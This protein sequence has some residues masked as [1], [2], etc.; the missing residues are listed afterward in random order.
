MHYTIFQKA[1]TSMIK[2]SIICAPSKALFKLLLSCC[3]LTSCPFYLQALMYTRR[4]YRGYPVNEIR[5]F[6]DTPK[7]YKCPLFLSHFKTNFI[8]IKTPCTDQCLYKTG[9]LMYS[10]QSKISDKTIS[11][12]VFISL[13]FQ[14]I[15]HRS[16]LQ[17]SR[18]L[19]DKFHENPE[20]TK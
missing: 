15:T 11:C 14:N 5:L 10:E 6:N 20:K 7:D 4:L 12:L 2:I 8:V 19:E 13:L 17:K 3:H 18:L 9:A 16:S 1:T